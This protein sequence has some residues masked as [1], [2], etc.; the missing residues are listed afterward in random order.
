MGD[1][2]KEISKV[3]VEIFGGTYTVRATESQGHVMQVADTLDK[4]MLSIANR[5]R[6]LSTTQVA[7]LAALNL[8]DELVKLQEDYQSLVKILAEDKK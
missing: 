1:K 8:A 4:R 6:R 5:N 3:K 2:E 7:V